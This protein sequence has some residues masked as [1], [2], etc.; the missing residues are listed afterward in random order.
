MQ[1][2]MQIAVSAMIFFINGNVAVI[3]KVKNGI[4]LILSL[5]RA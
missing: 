1:S 2:K 3:E 5:K 4:Q